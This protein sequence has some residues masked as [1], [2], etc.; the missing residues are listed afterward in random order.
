MSMRKITRKSKV[1]SSSMTIGEVEEWLEAE[2]EKARR[3]I[4]RKPKSTSS[5]KIIIKKE[6]GNA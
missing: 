6:P 2:F 5:H 3:R 1:L 4:G